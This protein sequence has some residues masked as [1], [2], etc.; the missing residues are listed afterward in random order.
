MQT[1]SLTIVPMML[2]PVQTNAYLVADPLARLAAVIDPAWDGAAI[3]REAEQRGW[4]ITDI[5]LT[6]A[7]FDHFG[8]AGGVADGVDPAP[9]IAMHPLDQPLWRLNGGAAWFGMPAF[10]PGPEPVVELAD[11][12]QL[13]L[14]AF[15]FEVRHAPGHSPGHVMFYC[16]QGGCLFC[17][18]VLFDG[19]VGR[20][21]L[22]GG[23]W[24]TLI[25]T[26]RSRI[27]DL[28]DEVQ[29]YSG[30]GAPTTVGRE[31]R[32]NPFLAG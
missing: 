26:I 18:D 24:D 12:M 14:G 11:G 28:P 1:A 2:G 8:G 25:N 19:S 17:G 32:S 9:R 10:D 29:V 31:R 6:H 30:H 3:V 15:T 20:S 16:A 7:H 4:R 13:A 5:W 22:P 21:D 23:D 27:L